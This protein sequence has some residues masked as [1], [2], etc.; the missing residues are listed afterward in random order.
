MIG[1]TPFSEN[2]LS[3][4]EINTQIRAC[5]NVPHFKSLE[6]FGEVSG[7]KF[8]GAHAYFTL[9]DKYS[10]MQCVCFNAKKTYT[11]KD[12]ESVLVW[13]GLDYYAK[14]GRLS[15]QVATIT[16]VGQG[17]L[18]LEFE[19][20]KAKL[21]QEG[22][23]DEKYKKHIPQYA[24]NVLVLTSKTGAVICDIVTTIRKKNPII[25]ITVKDVRVQGDRAGKEIAKVLANVDALG[26]D[27]IVIARGG[28]SL[29]D[30]APFYDEV[31]IRAIFNAKTPIVSAIGHETDFSLADFVADK[32]APT[33]TS[34]G[35]IV[36]YDY[37][38]LVNQ[39]KFLNESMQKIVKRLYESKTIKTKLQIEK[40]QKEIANYYALKNNQ[41]KKLN[42]NMVMIMDNKIIKKDNQLK[43][44]MESLDNLNPLKILKRG[45][46]K[47]EIE[48]KAINKIGDI[49]IG[50]KVSAVGSDGNFKAEVVEINLD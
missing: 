2:T 17:L 11:P 35:E 18:F 7:F 19:R 40:L 44:A 33:P 15:F 8:S 9:K 3:V 29:E 46:F 25:N 16:P 22:L 28:G 23:F 43:I 41:L 10:Q 37:Y 21:Q 6:V 36:A 32:R 39:I 48:N 50:D 31:L 4:S 20:L 34:A 1:K 45:Y 27:I 14:G 5:F 26:Y 12:G 13:G 30:L 42:S 47:I 38:A 24:K 49:K